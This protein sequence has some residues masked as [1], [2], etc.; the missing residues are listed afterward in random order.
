MQ[1]LFLFWDKAPIA[2][3]SA[4]PAK[5]SKNKTRLKLE[6]LEIKS[7]FGENPLFKERNLNPTDRI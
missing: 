4:W 2:E 3:N 6:R 7:F 5:T 1:Q